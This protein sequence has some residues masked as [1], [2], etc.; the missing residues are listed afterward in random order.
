MNFEIKGCKICVSYFC[1]TLLATAFV[2]DIAGEL[3]ICLVAAIFH[4]IGHITAIL[5]LSRKKPE[6]IK[7]TPF[8]IHINANIEF[9]TTLIQ[10]IIISLA[11]PTVN[12][13]IFI[14]MLMSGMTETD[15]H[16]YF[17]FENLMLF[18]F[19]LIPVLPLDGGVILFEI[20]SRYFDI[21]KAERLINYVSFFVIVPIFSIG[22]Y[23]LLNSKGNYLFLFI[24]C[25][26]TVMILVKNR[27][28]FG[29][30]KNRKKNFYHISR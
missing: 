7:I 4:E 17:L 3:L 28:E 5:L 9:K 1:F 19:N 13:I 10:K 30:N 14:A 2:M 22:F 25:Y 21:E 27:F 20:F 23:F 26:L 6:N 11:G 15:V 16:R 24:A 29:S 12:L 18:S 8:G